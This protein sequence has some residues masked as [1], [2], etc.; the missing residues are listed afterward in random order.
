VFND[1]A[2]ASLTDKDVKDVNQIRLTAGEPIR[3]GSELEH[4]VIRGA[5]G[6]LEFVDVA[7]VGADALLVHDP[8]RPDA[9]LAFSLAKLAETPTAPT[10]IGIF[11]DVERPVF[12]Q[13]AATEP[14]TEEQLADLL[15]GG[16]TW[17]VA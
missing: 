6:S 16:E 1:G 9:G 15:G 7:E 2:F 5:D 4:G 10:P 14:A 8:G 3:F 11:R 12:H 13:R 17:T